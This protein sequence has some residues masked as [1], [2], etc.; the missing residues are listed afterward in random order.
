VVIQDYAS[1]PASVDEFVQGGIK[2]TLAVPIMSGEKVFGALGLF[3][4]MEKRAFSQRDVAIVC[5]V[6]RQA[7]VAIEN[8]RLYE[9]MRSYARQVLSAQ[10]AERRRMAR[11]LHDDTAQTLVVLSRQLDALLELQD[12]APDRT[13]ER[14]QELRQLSADISH[15][16][17]RFIQDLRPS[18]LDDLGLL[19]TL[20]WLTA[21]L[22]EEDGVEARVEVLGDGRR[23]PVETELV[24][25]RVAQE[26]LNNVRK[27]SQATEVVTTVEFG[28]GA[29][30]ISIKDNGRGFKVPSEL[31]QLVK[32]GKLG[33][34][35]MF[36]RVQL[37]G[38][39]LSV[40]SQ[41][42]E[43]TTVVARIPYQQ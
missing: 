10:E 39:T 26:A 32:T 37:V 13:R 6:A 18:T 2:S 25:F 15:G 40:R 29:V 31:G 14:L 38:G 23:L 21:K 22:S 34:T 20:K 3:T 43:A 1:H 41:P 19:P 36:E 33:L 30:T 5:A 28:D 8:A 35:G 17:R 7:A 24:L 27:H 12:P 9:S 16:V 11:E 4:L 42:G